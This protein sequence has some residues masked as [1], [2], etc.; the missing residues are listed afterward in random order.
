MKKLLSF[1]VMAG[2]FFIGAP[3]LVVGV[4]KMFEP[5][6][7]A[8]VYGAALQAVAVCLAIAGRRAVAALTPGWPKWVFKD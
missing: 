5:S 3:A 6:G 4:S 1:A 2:T 8:W 7:L